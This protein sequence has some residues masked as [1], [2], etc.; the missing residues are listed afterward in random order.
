MSMEEPK[1][2]KRKVKAEP[3]EE[4]EDEEF[5]GQEEDS[6]VQKND[7][8]ELFF[9]LGNKKRC[10]IRSFKGNTLIDIREVSTF[11]AIFKAYRPQISFLILVLISTVSR[12][13]Q[14]YEKDGKSMPGKKG[15]SLNIQQ[16]EVLSHFIKAGHVDKAIED[17]GK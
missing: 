14:F 15:I 2:K 10:T 17:L 3:E 9:E 1:E 16:F 11:P 13:L 12:F 6:P 7:Q 5:D 4:D 8:G